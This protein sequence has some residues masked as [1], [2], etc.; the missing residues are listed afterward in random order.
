MLK[1]KL[2]DIPVTLTN[3]GGSP[4]SGITLT[5]SAT[6]GIT[7]SILN[8]GTDTLAA[9][10]KRTITLRIAADANAPDSGAASLDIATAEGLT[11][12]V[13]T[14]MSMVSPIPLITTSP[15]YIETG[16]MRGNQ[17]IATFTV[18][19]VG[20]STLMNPR[21]E[22]PSLPWLSLTV[23]K[24]IGDCLDSECAARGI[25]AG[26]SKTIG[27]VLSPSNTLT[28]DVYYDRLVIYADNHVP[29]TYNIKA[30][31]TS[32]AV[33]SVQFSLLDELLN[34]VDG[35]SITIQNQSVTEL[36]YTLTT[37]TDGT[38]SL[39]DIPEGRYSFNIT[40]AGHK[41]YGGSFVITP[42]VWTTVPVG[43]EVNLVQV[44]WSV[45][46]T[47][48]QDQYQITI[49]QTFAT[50]VPAPVLVTD[51]PSLTLPA[52]QPG[53]VFNGEFTVTNHG[54]IAVDNP[55]INFP[56][57]F[58]DYDIEVLAGV[59]P[60]HI[61]AMEKITIPYRVTRRQQTAFLPGMINADSYVASICSEVG[62][63]GGGGCVT[64]TIIW[65]A[66]TAV[67]C[68]N[69]PQE[70]TVDIQTPHIIVVPTDCLPGG[71]PGTYVAPP[72]PQPI[73]IGGVCTNCQSGNTG[74]GIPGGSPTPIHTDNPCD[75]KPDGSPCPDDGDS[76]TCDVCK[77][78]TCTHLPQDQCY[79]VGK[80]DG[81]PCDDL[82]YCT[83][84]DGETPKIDRCYGGVCK[85]KEIEDE[86]GTSVTILQPPDDVISICTSKLKTLL[87]LVPRIEDKLSISYSGSTQS[88]KR[89]CEK[90]ED[91]KTGQQVKLS[92]TV[93]VS[94]PEVPF[95]SIPIPWC[96]AVAIFLS[97]QGSG[98]VTGTVLRDD[99]PCQDDCSGSTK[100]EGSAK[101][102]V[103]AELA[104][105]FMLLD[106]PLSVKGS[107]SVSGGG[108]YTFKC[109]GEKSG[110]MCAGEF[111]LSIGIMGKGW[112]KVGLKHKIKDAYCF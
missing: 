11:G 63:F 89:C 104:P 81:T 60:Q 69:T 73:Y 100:I 64:S 17:R 43:L 9:A 8:P 40:A 86:E 66:G 91:F 29:Y 72:P 26:Q 112:T 23:D 96:P 68:P 30:A 77:G 37:A 44:E 42:G 87:Q 20:Y 76:S 35:A 48:I 34:K 14:N 62:G 56:T 32:S 98:E 49:N 71:A 88:I 55:K 110:K 18:S 93:G 83:S 38:A 58:G 10:E 27:I 85:G 2:Q 84:Y 24:N 25:K 4:L 67:I 102:T 53:Q 57:S 108:E 36:L 59:M 52:M 5:T 109:T 12:K 78:G 80:D 16:L 105:T 103:N 111:V 92:G 95:G 47:T 13:D 94:T 75:C 19:N 41:P 31:V 46:P 61:G 107:A 82:K 7:A 51:P 3:L 15:S 65:V 21:I 50:N 28:Q 39:T 6:S 101:I 99:N 1:G 70:R 22:G 79:C 45:T 33:G 106:S 74:G 97:I 90:S 54:L